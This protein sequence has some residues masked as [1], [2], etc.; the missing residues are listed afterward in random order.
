M[1]R[2]NGDESTPHDQ[3]LRQVLLGITLKYYLSSWYVNKPV[4]QTL[5]ILLA[6]HTTAALLDQ[7]KKVL[8][9]QD[10]NQAVH[11]CGQQS[12]SGW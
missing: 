1:Q 11:M 8:D 12:L 2:L 3:D 7:D 6:I 5:R 10:L 4:L 9:E